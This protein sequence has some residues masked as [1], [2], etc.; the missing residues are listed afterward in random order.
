MTGLTSGAS[1]AIHPVDRVRG[2]RT[3]KGG[4]TIGTRH[5]AQRTLVPR[6]PAG[7][8]RQSFHYPPAVP[9]CS[10]R[11]TDVE[12]LAVLQYILPIIHD[13]LTC[14]EYQYGLDG[15]RGGLSIEGQY[16]MGDFGEG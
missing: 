5:S 10:R 15:R 16:A 9:C 12:H 6:A 7:T 4:L 8:K 13:Q 3:E 11:M 14:N 1:L 2:G